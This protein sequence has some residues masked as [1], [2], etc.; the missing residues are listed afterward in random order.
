MY[1]L[2]KSHVY[3]VT[4]EC[5]NYNKNKFNTD[6]VSSHVEEPDF[7]HLS[8]FIIDNTDKISIRQPQLDAPITPHKQRFRYLFNLP[9]NLADEYRYCIERDDGNCAG[10]NVLSG[11]PERRQ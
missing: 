1:L 6:H 2:T 10:N 3:A 9:S 7:C 5:I 4:R 8:N 11:E